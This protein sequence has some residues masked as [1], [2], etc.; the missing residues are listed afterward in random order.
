MTLTYK[1]KFNRKHGQPLNKSNSLND[2][3]RL[4]GYLLHDSGSILFDYRVVLACS[5]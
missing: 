3:S 1:L 2:I 4:S 5:A